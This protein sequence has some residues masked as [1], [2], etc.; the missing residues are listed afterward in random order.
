[1]FLSVFI[2]WI[3]LYLHNLNSLM[4]WLIQL[5]WIPMKYLINPEIMNENIFSFFAFYIQATQVAET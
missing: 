3:K 2:I 5:I 1:M 4:S